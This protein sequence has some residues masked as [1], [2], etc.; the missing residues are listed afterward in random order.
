MQGT[1]AIGLKEALFEAEARGLLPYLSAIVH[2][3]IVLCSVPDSEAEDVAIE[4]AAAMEAGM[5]KVCYS[6]P[7]PA[8]VEIGDYWK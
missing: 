6:L 5:R 4:L 1:A 7:T 8:E 2:D 3:E